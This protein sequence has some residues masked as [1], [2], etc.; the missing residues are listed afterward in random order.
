MSAGFVQVRWIDARDLPG[1]MAL[2]STRGGVV[3]C[4][5]LSLPERMSL[6]EIAHNAAHLV[7]GSDDER[8]DCAELTESILA[9]LSDGLRAA[10]LT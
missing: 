7:L 2:L 10:V 9:E 1:Q 3:V 6:E 8:H 4:I 5:S